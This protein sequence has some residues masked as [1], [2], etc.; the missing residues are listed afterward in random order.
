M[1]E[2]LLELSWQRKA[3]AWLRG[4]LVGSWL[5]G[6]L[7]PCAPHPSPLTLSPNPNS[8]HGTHF[9]QEE[10]FHSSQRCFLCKR[11]GDR[12]VSKRIGMVGRERL[13]LLPIDSDFF[14]LMPG[15]IFQFRDVSAI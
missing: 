7:A 14:Q 4:L 8:L 5:G 3:W 12:G 10:V 6:I 13:L 9:L 1:V 2:L 15:D 11:E